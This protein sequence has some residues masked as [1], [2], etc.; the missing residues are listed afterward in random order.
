MKQDCRRRHAGA[1][2]ADHSA[3]AANH[4]HGPDGKVIGRATTD[5]HGATTIYD[6]RSAASQA[7]PPPT[8]RRHN[9][10]RRER[11]QNW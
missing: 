5:S 8:P 2:H 6:P 9:D 1:A 4:L 3:G 10:L 7:A 11:T